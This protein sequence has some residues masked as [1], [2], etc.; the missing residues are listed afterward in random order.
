MPQGMSIRQFKKR[1]RRAIERI[2]DKTPIAFRDRNDR[3]RFIRTAVKMRMQMMREK[4]E[5]QNKM[6]EGA[7]GP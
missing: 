1:Y 5:H 2:A 4:N 7:A 6:P 3:K